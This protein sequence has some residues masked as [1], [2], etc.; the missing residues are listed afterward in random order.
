[1]NENEIVA[2]MSKLGGSMAALADLQVAIATAIVKK[3]SD[4]SDDERKHFLDGLRNVTDSAKQ[5]RE[6]L[7]QLSAS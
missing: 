4:F 3:S 1:M 6:S 5:L 2:F 7:R